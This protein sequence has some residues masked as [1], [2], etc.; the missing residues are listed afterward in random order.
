M[1]SFSLYTPLI[2]GHVEK[3]QL[4]NMVMLLQAVVAVLHFTTS[5]VV[6]LMHPEN[7]TLPTAKKITV[8]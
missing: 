6:I 4:M 1:E 2:L 5:K 8:V 3:L 7:T